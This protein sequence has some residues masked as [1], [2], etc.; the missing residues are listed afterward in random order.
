MNVAGVLVHAHP[1]KLARVSAALGELPGVEI[2]LAAADGRLVVTAEDTAE[3]SAGDS[4]LAMHRMDGVLSATLVYHN[5]DPA[6]SGD[7]PSGESLSGQRESD[8][9]AVT[10]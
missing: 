2:H 6:L 9:A 5:F 8:H 3:V 7:T 10:A 1:D 4:I